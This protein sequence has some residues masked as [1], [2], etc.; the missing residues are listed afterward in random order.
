[1]TGNDA[2]ATEF[3]QRV[4]SAGVYRNVSTRFADGFV[5]GFGA[6]VGIATGKI[7]ARGPMGLEGLT[8][9]KYKLLGDGQLLAEMKDGTRHY[10]PP[11]SGSIVPPVTLAGSLRGGKVR[12]VFSQALR[13]ETD[14]GAACEIRLVRL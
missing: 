9:Y 1:M 7:H 6:E 8:T 2:A 3:L 12:A 10:N 14:A 11:G 5:Y 13:K 4:D